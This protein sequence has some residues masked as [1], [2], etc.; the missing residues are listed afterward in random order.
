MTN[1]PPRQQ[2]NGADSTHGV[3]LGGGAALLMILCCAGPALI[4]SGSLAVLGGWLA[5]SW[6][7][8]LAGLAVVIVVF[9]ARRTR[10]NATHDCCAP[11]APAD[12]ST[13]PGHAREQDR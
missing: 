12:H 9:L 7:I 2:K 11:T 8:G 6:V 4:A 10:S 3:L 13:T 5:R 1:Q